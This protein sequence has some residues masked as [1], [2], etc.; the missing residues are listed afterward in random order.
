MT[1]GL[2][3]APQARGC[4]G[5]RSASSSARQPVALPVRT[6]GMAHDPE[7]GMSASPMSRQ[8]QQAPGGARPNRGGQRL[9]PLCPGEGGWETPL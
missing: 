4:S 6:L 2:L 9:A 1:G 8:S 7:N 3:G 5:G